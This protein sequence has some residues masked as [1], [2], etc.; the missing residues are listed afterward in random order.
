MSFADPKSLAALQADASGS[1][2]AWTTGSEERVV[3]WEWTTTDAWFLEPLFAERRNAQCRRDGRAALF[4]KAKILAQAPT[5]PPSGSRCYGY[6]AQERVVVVREYLSAT[7]YAQQCYVW[8]D[9]RVTWVVFN[10]QRWPQ[11][12]GEAELDEAGRVVSLRSGG[13]AALFSWRDDR[14]VRVETQYAT[15]G[16]PQLETEEELAAALEVQPKRRRKAAALLAAIEPQ[17]VD[18]VVAAF[19][20]LALDEPA[21]CLIVSFAG[22]GN[23]PF[24]PLLGVGLESERRALLAQKQSGALEAPLS[25]LLWNVGDFDHYPQTELTDGALVQELNQAIFEEEAWK[26][27]AA[28]FERVAQRLRNRT[29]SPVTDDFVI[30]AIDFDGSQQSAALRKAV[31]PT[32]FAAWK[33]AG[34]VE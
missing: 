24:P 25:E 1:H 15:G 9:R 6:D 26:A 34:W 27:T 28:C 8:A 19:E 3:R 18:A 23:A 12:C 11:R 7:T 33:R 20:S 17:V 10:G 13:Y 16:V 29:W 14:L 32:R 2:A 21:Y 22:R 31:G 4:K 5:P 30:A